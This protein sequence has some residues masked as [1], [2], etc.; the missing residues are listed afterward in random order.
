MRAHT[1]P[2]RVVVTGIESALISQRIKSLEPTLEVVS[3]TATGGDTLGLSAHSGGGYD[4]V[5]VSQPY[6]VISDGASLTALHKA[7]H[8]EEGTLGMLWARALPSEGWVA[9]YSRGVAGAGGGMKGGLPLLALNASPLTWMDEVGLGKFGF[10]APKHRKFVEKFEGGSGNL[11]I[12]LIHCALL[13]HLTLL[14]PLFFLSSCT[15][16]SLDEL[17]PLMPWLHDAR[18]P[19]GEVSGSQKAGELAAKAT[20]VGALMVDY[21]AFHCETSAGV[22]AKRAK[23]QK[24]EEAAKQGVKQ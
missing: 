22:A 4:G 10:E 19:L 16:G 18:L 17:L 11:A 7:L 20:G 1:R 15:L 23:K 5:I 21:H 6:H 13:I 9:A 8:P 2:L 14:N 12:G 24:E 3:A